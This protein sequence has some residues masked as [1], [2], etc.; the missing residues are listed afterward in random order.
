MEGEDVI[1]D[2]EVEQLKED[3]K[4]ETGSMTPKCYIS[5]WVPVESPA[6]RIERAKEQ[7]AKVVT[8]PSIIQED[9]SSKDTDS[10]GKKDEEGPAVANKMLN[11][12]GVETGLTPVMRKLSVGSKADSDQGQGDGSPKA[13]RERKKSKSK[14][15]DKASEEE[16]KQ[17]EA[18][19]PKTPTKTGAG[20]ESKSPKK[21]SPEKQPSKI[22]VKV[23]SE[24]EESSVTKPEETAA[25]N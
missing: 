10:N 12:L 7:L 22:P 9:T 19:A 17:E 14:T 3:A 24:Q 20:G 8:K 16:M 18:A 25:A 6:E 21:K 11:G 13:K 15:E 2:D 5:I 1:S 4:K 23:P